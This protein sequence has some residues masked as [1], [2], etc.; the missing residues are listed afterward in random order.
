MNDE[1]IVYDTEYW[2]DEG[3]LERGWQG[4]DDHLPVLIQIGAYRVKL[5]EELP[6]SKEWLSYISPIGRDGKIIK[7]TDYFSNLT[8]ITQEKINKDGKHPKFAIPEFSDFVGQRKM[9][10]YGNDI[11]DTFLPTCFI[12][13][14]KCPFH[15]SQEKD[16]RHILRKSGVTEEEINANRSGSI[17]QHFGVFMDQH[18]EHDAKDD[19][20]SILEA[21]RYL[22]KNGSLEMDWFK[23]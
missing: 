5:V 14:L 20:L 18:H 3:V 19:A 6:A 8:G 12:N 22:V 7:L 15:I 4:L 2:T 1:I 10:S 21:L 17:A 16:V 23:E 13:G 9:Y 11:V